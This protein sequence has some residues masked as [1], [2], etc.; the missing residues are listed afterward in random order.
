M[1]TPKR[2]LT[3]TSLRAIL[4]TIFVVVIILGIVVFF[5]GYQRII[6]YAN[7][8]AQIANQAEA[9]SHVL[10]DLE[11]LRTSLDQ[12][13]DAAKSANEMVASSSDY[14]YQ[15]QIIEIVTAKAN[16]VGVTLDNVSFTSTATAAGQTS[17]SATAA[18]TAPAAGGVSAAPMPAGLRTAAATVTLKNPV[19]YNKLLNFLY[20]LEKSV[21]SINVSSINLTKSASDTSGNTVECGPLNIEVYIR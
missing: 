5:F 10:Q 2:H 15:E 8:T 6:T 19:N 4:A 12:E 21:P 16:S 11:A 18:G 1:S 7:S 9:S 17:G 14:K 3:A 13:A 20:A